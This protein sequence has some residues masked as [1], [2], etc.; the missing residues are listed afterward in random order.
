MHW[1]RNVET[2]S[3]SKANLS[4]RKHSRTLLLL[5][6]K[7]S[8]SG[9]HMLCKLPPPTWVAAT[10]IGEIFA[11]PGVQILDA[12]CLIGTPPRQKRK[13]KGTLTWFL[14][15]LGRNAPTWQPNWEVSHRMGHSKQQHPQGLVSQIISRQLFSVIVDNATKLVRWK[16]WVLWWL[17]H[18]RTCFTPRREV[19]DQLSRV[20]DSAY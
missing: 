3:D 15:F 17:S 13:D 14:R 2:S 11:C 9:G 1:E 20:H 6:C 10:V 18:R 8:D 12:S 7:A 5:E 16:G 19:L 4:L